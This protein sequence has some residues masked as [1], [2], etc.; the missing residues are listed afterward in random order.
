MR[1][2]PRLTYDGR[3]GGGP[4]GRGFCAASG[5]VVGLAFAC[6]AEGADA[7]FPRPIEGHYL[8]NG[9][10]V[11]LAPDDTMSDVSL[12]VRYEAGHRDDPDGREGLAH[13]TEHVLFG[14]FRH[15]AHAKLLLETG[16]SNLNAHTGFDFTSFEE[17]VSP[18]AL[19]LAL[20]LEGA[21][22][23]TARDALDES[24]VVRERSV[25]GLEYRQYG[26]GQTG[27][28]ALGLLFEFEWDELYPEWHPYHFAPD[29]LA[30]L[31][32][33]DAADVRAF[34]RTW[35]CPNNASVVLAGHFEPGRALDLVQK[36]FGGIS[37]RPT[38]ARPAL[39]SLPA[40]GNLW[41]DVEA[42]VVHPVAVMA[43]R[44]PTR[45]AREDRALTVV[46]WLLTAPH[47]P[48]GPRF[49][50]DD[51]GALHITVNKISAVAGSLFAVG[52]EP[53]EGI[54]LA[55]L[56][57][58]VQAAMAAFP[59]QVTEADV[60]QV[61]KRLSDGQLLGLEASMGRALRLADP[62]GMASWGVDDYDSVDRASVVDSMRRLLAPE[63]RVTM[64]VRPA[65]RPLFGAP[66]VLLH[67]DRMA[68]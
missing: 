34:A 51:T 44:G 60:A 30:A 61:K 57:P 19:D 11:V 20:W 35:Y 63:Q 28:Q 2:T 5:I 15:G 26:H 16:A 22:M 38:P 24:V 46:A 25:A 17:T 58:A 6:S 21:R 59:N 41:L 12:V 45:Y 3:M 33:I 18:E 13:V 10:R 1:R 36:Y 29:A 54:S 7:P 23:A 8:A 4:L 56:L 66:A 53:R 43:W 14:A 64:V 49:L 47:G 62:Q 27:F 37:A 9:L 31:N 52:V 39:P 50:N 68:R 67:R 40:P 32:R 65:T 55:K 42:L 48:L